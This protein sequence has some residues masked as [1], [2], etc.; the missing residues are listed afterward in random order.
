MFYRHGGSTIDGERE[1]KKR[2]LASKGVFGWVVAF[3]TAVVGCGFC[4]SCFE[5]AAVV[6][7]PPLTYE[8]G[9]HFI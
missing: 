2:P 8:S 3:A 1:K 6:Y 5:E 9:P 7:L 4:K